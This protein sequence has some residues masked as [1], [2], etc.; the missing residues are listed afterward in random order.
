M[1]AEAV[2]KELPSARAQE[3]EDVLEVRSGARR[4]AKRRRIERA[5]PPGEEQEARETAD[6]LE[7]TRADVLVRQAIAREMEDWPQEERRESRAARGAG[8]GARRHVERDDHGCP[9]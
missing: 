4:G 9:S 5:S 6:D 1:P 2:V 3:R 7:A 8:R